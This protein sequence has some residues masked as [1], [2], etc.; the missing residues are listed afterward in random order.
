MT[1][2]AAV[3]TRTHREEWA[4]IVAGL[5]R[6]LGDLDLAEEMAADAFATAVEHWPAHGVPPNPPGWLTTTANRKAIDR[7]RRE[8]RREDKHREAL[9]L[10]DPE[11]AEPTG[12]VEDDRLRLLFIC[13]HPALPLE[14]RVALTLRMLGGLTVAEIAHAFLVQDTTMGQRISR[15]K[16]KIKTAGIPFSN[17]EPDDLPARVDGVLTVL[18]L[19]FNEGYLASAP[20][21]PPI[22]RDLT[23][24]AIRLT[25]LTRELLPDDAEVTGLL[26]LMLLT[27]ARARTRLSTDGELVR[28]D[29]QD[30]GAWD[31]ALIAEGLQL[32]ETS[33][34]TDAPPGRYRLLASINAE[35][36]SAPHAR[37]TDWARIVTLYTR[38]EEIDPS[39]I[40]TLNK[41]IAV[42]EHDSPDVA[43]AIVDRLADSLDGFHAFHATRAE[44]L[45]ATGR[46]ADA[47]IAYDRAIDLAGNTAE[48]AHLSRR[49]N[50]LAA[51]NGARS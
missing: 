19:V 45:R 12:A 14:A 48:T 21:A 42:S 18:Y 29:E 31:R 46:S 49:R 17:P 27:E 20:D 47:R 26:A 23:A 7:L 37:D 4:R 30:R 50:Q 44:L 34:T 32:L 16:A 43:L 39:P 11:P 41:A 40:V 24:E 33:D 3:I 15:A 8:A 38:L 6:R 36:V 35:H 9:M 22:R 28:L 13:C 51:P 1:D 2:V 5:T 10:H 25:R